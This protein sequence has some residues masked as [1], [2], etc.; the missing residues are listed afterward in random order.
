MTGRVILI[1]HGQSVGNESRRF[2]E[3]DE[4]ALTDLGKAQAGIAAGVL[5]TR[6]SPV[7]LVASPFRRALH[8][9]ELIGRQIGLDVEVQEA[10]RE[11]H[12]G[13]LRGQPYEAA[14]ETPGFDLHSRWEWH[15]PGGDSLLEVQDRAAPAIRKI[16]REHPEEHAVV[17]CH[18]GTIWA[19]WSHVIGTW[20]KASGIGNCDLLVLPHDGA[21][22]GDPE[23][24]PTSDPE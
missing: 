5:Q 3:T 24:I 23:L 17:V 22:F 9:A 16:A 21:A 18:G 14:L 2:T 12:F 20:E 1:R 19:L 13:E 4:A 7:R 8:T 10:F 6:F 11:Q 15:P